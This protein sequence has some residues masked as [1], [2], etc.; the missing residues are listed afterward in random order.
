MDLRN[1]RKRGVSIQF[2]DKLKSRCFT[3]QGMDIDTLF[4]NVLNYCRAW[5][6][7]GTENMGVIYYGEKKEINASRD[8][9]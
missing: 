1:F 4:S 7:N 5:S 3:V 2:K 6:Q 8:K 9:P